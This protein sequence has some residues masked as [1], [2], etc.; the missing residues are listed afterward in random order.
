VLDADGVDDE[1]MLAF[2]RETKLA[3][4]TFVQT[5]GVD[6]ADYRNRIFTTAREV[7]FAGHPSLGTA[8]A[9]AVAR[10]VDEARY[11]QQTGAGLQPVEVSHRDGA[12]SASIL[13]G[14][15]V[16]GEEVNP[17]HVM[18]AIG[19]LT[20]DAHRDLPPQVVSTGLPTLVTLVLDEAA[21]PRSVPDFELIEP[22]LAACGA[23]NVYVAWHDGAGKVRARM[24]TR[25]AEGGEDA[26]TGSAA[27]PLCAY[28]AARGRTDRV[29][30]VQGVEMGRPSR[31]EAAIE[32]DRVRVG[33]GVVPVIEGQVSL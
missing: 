30:I 18:A 28:L 33:G 27:A 9:V 20:G 26:A 21:I 31:L 4:T 16:F 19:L 22:L 29:G 13:Q 8:V 23:A 32:G 10:G 1:T 12:W 5:A 17:S 14:P 25:P 11:V 24:F 3:E 6:G 7:P 15:A 2:A